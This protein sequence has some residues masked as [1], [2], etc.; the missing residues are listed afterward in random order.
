MRYVACQS[1]L[2]ALLCLATQA[3]NAQVDRAALNGT[4]TDPSGA[5]VPGA[6]VSAEAPTIGVKRQTLTD[7]AGVYRLPSLPVGSYVL[8]VAKD[9]F[10]TKK[11]EGLVLAVG[12][13]RTLD[14]SLDITATATEV[15]VTA[16]APALQQNNAEIGLAID[17]N[18]VSAIP[19]NGRN[20]TGL[21]MLAPGAT[22]TGEGNQNTIRFNGRS[23][24]DN[25]FTFD[26]VDA[27]GVKDPRQEA[28]LRLNISLD[29]ISEFRVS[30]GLYNAE[31]GTAPSA[32][33]FRSPA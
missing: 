20:W 4:V 28:N 10:Q 30:G 1:L 24:D 25:N 31:S 18:Q 15:I 11:I 3:V 16:E 32:R 29:S 12:Q 14:V 6:Q 8:T 13:V 7:A 5:M 22:N 26:G 33:A 27:T 21:L 9:G 23:R 17:Q 2:L 19:L